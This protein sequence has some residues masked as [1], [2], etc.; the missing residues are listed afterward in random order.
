MKLNGIRYQSLSIQS[1]LF[2]FTVGGGI[3]RFDENIPITVAKLLYVNRLLNIIH[4]H[5]PKAK[6]IFDTDPQDLETLLSS[7]T[8]KRVFR[9]H[10]S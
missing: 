8:W 7:S 9:N 10:V 6:F 3:N 4:K 5:V 1:N 2:S